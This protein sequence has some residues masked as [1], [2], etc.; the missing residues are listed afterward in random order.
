MLT[1]HLEV[2]CAIIRQ[3]GTLWTQKATALPTK[4]G[5]AY[6]LNLDYFPC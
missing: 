1:M 3:V 6:R 4:D 5:S 2:R